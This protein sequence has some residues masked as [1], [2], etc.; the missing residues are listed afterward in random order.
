MLALYGFIHLS[1]PISPFP[2]TR[3]DWLFSL[4]ESLYTP[5]R[6]LHPWGQRNGSPTLYDSRTMGWCAWWG[7]SPRVGPLVQRFI[8][9]DPSSLDNLS[10]SLPICFLPFHLTWFLVGASVNLH[11]RYLSLQGFHL[12]Q[13][14]SLPALIII[15]PHHL[16]STSPCDISWSYSSLTYR[17]LS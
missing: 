17:F 8:S 9:T 5:P 12:Q 4:F 7:C 1:Y 13:S 3:Y 10:Y 14:F 16:W 15:G 6:P 2:I 11:P